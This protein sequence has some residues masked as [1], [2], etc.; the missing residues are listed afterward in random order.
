MAHQLADRVHVHRHEDGCV[1]RDCPDHYHRWVKRQAESTVLR[2]EGQKFIQRVV[3][4]YDKETRVDS[5][6][7]LAD[8]FR[9]TYSLL[10]FV[11]ANGGLVI[12]HHE[13]IPS[14][15]NSRDDKE[16]GPHFHCLVDGQLDP[17][18]TLDVFEQTRT[19]IR[20]MGKPRCLTAHLEYVLSH[21]GVPRE[22]VP[23]SLETLDHYLYGEHPG[24]VVDLNP[25]PDGIM[26]CR[27][28]TIRWF[29]TWCRL[30]KPHEDGRFCAICGHSIPLG[31][32]GRPIW[33]N[34]DRPPPDDPWVDGDGKDWVIQNGY[35]NGE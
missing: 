34:L 29:G 2:L 5:D 11:G 26:Q 6:N 23:G 20:G 7:S 13:R 4:S 15:Y 24:T 18:K 1:N 35:G 21:L 19:V 14:K 28:H 9:E 30:K 33:L 3:V 22:R 12:Y 10:R 27:L 25:A 31:E 8:K 32:W 17:E 16:E